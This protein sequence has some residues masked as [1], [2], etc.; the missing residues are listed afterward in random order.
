MRATRWIPLFTAVLVACVAAI[1]SG[2]ATKSVT[3]ACGA[4]EAQKDSGGYW[5]CTFGDDFDGTTL[6]PG[7]WEAVTTAAAGFSQAGECYVDDPSHIKVGDGVLTLTATKLPSPAPCGPITSQ[8]QSAMITTK[9]SFAQTYGRFEVRAKLPEGS[10]FQSAFWLY[11]RDLAYEN[12]SGEI[13]VA[14]S[15]GAR[16]DVVSPHIHLLDANGVDRG[17]G[18]YCDVSNSGGSFHTYAVEWLRSEGFRFVYDG[19]PC[20]T[21]SGWDPGT[22]LA[23]PQPFDQPFY[24]L[25][26]LA[27]GYGGNAVT[28]STPFPATYVIDYVRAWK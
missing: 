26:Q 22:P 19:V 20:M 18:A 23:A 14:E 25:L 28:I 21:V 16:P 15:F 12:R 1:S 3:T 13:D 9:A 17:Q 6:D 24:M 7:R 11:P 4:T 27:L 8:Y 10:G 2:C 5:V